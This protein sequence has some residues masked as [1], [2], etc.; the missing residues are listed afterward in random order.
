M[1]MTVRVMRMRVGYCG[2][3]LGCC[4]C[5]GV[6]LS[7]VHLDKEH[8]AQKCQF[9]QSS[10][11]IVAAPS[12][13]SES[14]RVGASQRRRRTRNKNKRDDSNLAGEFVDER[15]RLTSLVT[16][17]ADGGLV[18]DV[19]E[20]HEEVIFEHFVGAD[21]VV[22]QIALE[23]V[24]LLAHVGEVDEEARAHVPLERLDLVRIRRL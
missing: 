6:L 5:L 24:A 13:R 20:D 10:G 2:C 3:C 17:E 18:D 15:Q 4:Q 22:P 7:I 12:A 16:H 14:E 19:V 1:R 8:R 9:Q 21:K 23:L 11:M